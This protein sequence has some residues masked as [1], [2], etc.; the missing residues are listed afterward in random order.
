MYLVWWAF[1]EVQWPLSCH[2]WPQWRS[3]LWSMSIECSLT[4][5]TKDRVRYCSKK[6]VPLAESSVWSLFTGN[7]DIFSIRK[8]A[9][10]R[11]SPLC[12]INGR[13]WRRSSGALSQFLFQGCFHA[14]YLVPLGPISP[15][16]KILYRRPGH[17]LSFSGDRYWSYFSRP[18]SDQLLYVGYFFLFLL[19]IEKL[20][21]FIA[22]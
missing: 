17:K 16:P 3:S 14:L 21:K 20:S 9:F 7:R 18:I 22:I 1:N 6:K 11:R 10:C 12:D 4:I 2:R 15:F 13:V 19:P 8:T 5:P